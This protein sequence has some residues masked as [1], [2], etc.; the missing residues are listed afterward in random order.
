V[1]ALGAACGDGGVAAAYV[2]AARH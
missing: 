1:W 2:T